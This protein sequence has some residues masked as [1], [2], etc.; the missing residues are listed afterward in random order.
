MLMQASMLERRAHEIEENIEYIDSQIFEL[1]S[2]KNSIESFSNSEEK[3]ILSS[4]GK[5]VFIDS[6]IE[7]K[8]LFVDVGANIIVK[9]TP[10]ETIKIIDSQ[11]SRITEARLGL[12]SSLDSCRNQL[13]NI[14]SQ[15]ENSGEGHKNI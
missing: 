13:N 14:I 10:Q 11:I 6:R 1:E 15:I 9:K 8:D 3:K 5:G 12:L 7:S 4:L 2:F